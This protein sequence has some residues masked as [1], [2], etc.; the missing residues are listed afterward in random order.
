MSSCCPVELSGIWLLPPTSSIPRNESD[1]APTLRTHDARLQPARSGFLHLPIR[2]KRLPNISCLTTIYL[3][4]G[5][6][7]L[8][9]QGFGPGPLWR[10]PLPPHHPQNQPFYGPA[11][12]FPGAARPQPATAP[13]GSHN[14][15]I[16]LQVGGITRIGRTHLLK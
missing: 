2:G 5:G 15:F 1:T 16:P 9:P 8:P 11:G 14:Q 4:A 3:P 13:I 7:L 6:M 10:M 12:T